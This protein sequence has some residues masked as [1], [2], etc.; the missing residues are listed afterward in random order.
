LSKVSENVNTRNKHKKSINKFLTTKN[1]NPL[2]IN[3]KESLSK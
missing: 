3:I 1:I 2:S